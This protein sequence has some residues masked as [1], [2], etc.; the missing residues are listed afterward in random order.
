M[1]HSSQSVAKTQFRRGLP[2]CCS[3]INSLKYRY[4]YGKIRTFDNSSF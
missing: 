2:A 1:W 4:S 3:N